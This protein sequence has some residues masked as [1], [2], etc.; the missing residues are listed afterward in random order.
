MIQAALDEARATGAAV[1]IP[2]VN[3]RTGKDI[4]DITKTIYLYDESTLL[5]QNCH[6]RLA[7]DVICNM[8]AN[9]NART[10][11]AIEQEG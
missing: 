11:I 6:L 2:K 9:E 4:W 8:F 5:L 3:Q 10:P 7:D 1:V